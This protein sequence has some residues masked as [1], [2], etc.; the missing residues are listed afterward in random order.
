MMVDVVTTL[1]LVGGAILLLSNGF[2]VTTEFALTRVRQFPSEEF[3][4]GGLERAWEMTERLEIYLSGCQ[5]GI[6]IS[7]VG[8]GVVAEPAVTAVIEVFLGGLG[9]GGGSGHAARSVLVALVVI[10]LLHVIIGEQ[11]PTYLGIE[12]TKTIA[13]YGAPLLYWWTK[14]MGPVIIV[15]D[16]V[17]KALLGL[18]GVDITRSWT[19]EELEEEPPSSRSELR[20]QMGETLRHAG[21]SDERQEEV[22]SALE[23]GDQPVKEIMIDRDSIVALSTT[24]DLET[25]LE[26]MRDSPHVRFPLIDED[27]MEFHGI[28]YTPAILQA[29]DEETLDID[30]D[31]IDLREFATPPMTVSTTTVVSDLIDR[32]QAE[33]QELALVVEDGDVVGLVTITDA[34]E[35]IIGEVEDPFDTAVDEAS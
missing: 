25:N 11:A 13:R 35:A 23:I 29:I 22:I 27:L 18:L 15:A 7:S 32:F 20:R 34:V 5:L 8:L 17:A 4:E 33:N 16:R 3:Q 6:T 19:E 24:D 21:L 12:R 1:R 14:L 26:R 2:F 31:A 9:I 28:V 30:P 10:N